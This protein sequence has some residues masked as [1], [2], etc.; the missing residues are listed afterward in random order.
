MLGQ[1]SQLGWQQTISNCQNE[2]KEMIIL[3]E[4]IQVF[5]KIAIQPDEYVTK[6]AENRTRVVCR[7]DIFTISN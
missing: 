6:P 5:N 7:V 1:I 4:V 2:F 3:A